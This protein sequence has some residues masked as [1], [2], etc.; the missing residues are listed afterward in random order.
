MRMES[1]YF[2]FN[3]Q[4]INPYSANNLLARDLIV[5][6]TDIFGQ[7]RVGKNNRHEKIQQHLFIQHI[8]A[9]NKSA[10]IKLPVS[11]IIHLNQYTPKANFYWQINLNVL[12]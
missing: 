4:D 12:V 10:T 8:K 9:I 3:P 6:P 1:L 5:E 7:L 2:K 11:I